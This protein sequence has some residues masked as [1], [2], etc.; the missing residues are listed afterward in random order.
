MIRKCKRFEVAF[1]YAK[2][3]A[4]WQIRFIHMVIGFVIGVTEF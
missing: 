4:I 2:P 3:I 1:F